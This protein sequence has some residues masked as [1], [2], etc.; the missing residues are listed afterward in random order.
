MSRQEVSLVFKLAC[1]VGEV[2]GTSR[3]VFRVTSRDQAL[4]APDTD[5][6]W[7]Y[8]DDEANEAQTRNVVVD[9]ALAE[10]EHAQAS[11]EALEL[12]RAGR[13]DAAQ[14]RLQR[15]AAAIAKW[16][17]GD[18]II[19]SVVSQMG[20]EAEACAAPMAPSMMKSQHFASMNQS[21]GRS[22]AGGARRRTTSEKIPK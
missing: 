13:Y 12:N 22:M 5:A 6:V 17:G 16:A 9:R 18:A 10:L 21:R 20:E 14:S 8:A 7:T 1:P 2:R 19:G 4:T 15:G 11:A 3:V